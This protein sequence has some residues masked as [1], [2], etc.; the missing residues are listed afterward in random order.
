MTLS[1]PNGCRKRRWPICATRSSTRS[2]HEKEHEIGARQGS[3][4]RQV[5]HEH[6]SFD[7]P[8]NLLKNETRQALAELV[9]R[10]RERGVP[11]EMLKEKEEGADR[12]RRLARGASLENELHSS[13]HR[14]AGKD[15]GDAR[16]DVDER[17]RHQAMHH[18]VTPEKM[19]KEIEKNDGMNGLAEADPAGQDN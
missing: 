18:N 2:E 11:D 6:I 5:P 1:R 19:R 16:E 15:P 13:S 3:A 17:I 14:R 12:R 9:Q 10:N 7:L 8:P 4:G